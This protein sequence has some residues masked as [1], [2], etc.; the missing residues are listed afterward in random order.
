MRIF[1]RDI[2]VA[3]ISVDEIVKSA[4]YNRIY[5]GADF[6]LSADSLVGEVLIKMPLQP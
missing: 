4:S 3:I 1:I 5:E 2:S 6:N